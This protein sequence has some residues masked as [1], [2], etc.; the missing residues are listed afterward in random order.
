MDEIRGRLEGERNKGSWF[1]SANVNKFRVIGKSIS[2]DGRT[3]N[4]EQEYQRTSEHGGREERLKH[5]I[6][7]AQ[8]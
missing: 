7:E 3:A 6:L 4:Q 2:C 8:K 1:V 5:T